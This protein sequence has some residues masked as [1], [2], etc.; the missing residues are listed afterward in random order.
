MGYD[1]DIRRMATLFFLLNFVML[2]SRL[3]A[4]TMKFIEVESGFNHQTK[5]AVEATRK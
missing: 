4:E 3:E 2:C 5:L 1:G